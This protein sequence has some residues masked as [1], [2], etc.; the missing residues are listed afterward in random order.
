MI[1]LIL[2]YDK[3]LFILIAVTLVTLRGLLVWTEEKLRS[4]NSKL[5]TAI[6]D[7]VTLLTWFDY[8]KAPALPL[9]LRAAITLTANITQSWLIF[10]IALITHISFLVTALRHISFKELNYYQRILGIIFLIAVTYISVLFSLPVNYKGVIQQFQVLANET[11]SKP[12]DSRQPPCNRKRSHPDSDDLSYIAKQRKLSSDSSTSYDSDYRDVSTAS[13]LT[14]KSDPGPPRPPYPDLN[15]KRKLGVSYAVHP[16]PQILAAQNNRNNPVIGPEGLK[17]VNK[18]IDKIVDPKK[19]ALANHAKAGLFWNPR[20][21]ATFR[22]W[23]TQW[24]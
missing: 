16:W 24:P 19:I 14:T 9:A 20:L 12:K 10:F 7:I 17:A 15:R 18:I 21:E 2:P 23:S 6:T 8:K 4:K 11:G 13:T 22:R 3:T 5:R 1:E